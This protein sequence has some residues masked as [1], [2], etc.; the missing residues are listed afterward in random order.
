MAHQPTNT[1]PVP[2]EDFRITLAR[3]A[4]AASKDAA[5]DFNTDHQAARQW[6]R[7]EVI[8]EQL[9]Q[10][11]DERAARDAA[12]EAAARKPVDDLMATCAEI[13]AERNARG[14]R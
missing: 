14:E 8:V 13:Q 10:V 5:D 3:K 9:L 7:L 2:A 6:G 4:L 11:I 1:R 12:L